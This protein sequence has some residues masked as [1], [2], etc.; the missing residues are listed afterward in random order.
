MVGLYLKKD[1]IN[2]TH[3]LKD[4]TGTECKFVLPTDYID[5]VLQEE[6]V[7]PRRE[8]DDGGI[9]FTA[10]SPRRYYACDTN[11]F[12]FLNLNIGRCARSITQR[13]GLTMLL[14]DLFIDC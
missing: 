11:V 8:A 7:Q 6:D 1:T 12:S 3:K 5:E 9:T 2:T 14:I 4:E 10:K 13:T